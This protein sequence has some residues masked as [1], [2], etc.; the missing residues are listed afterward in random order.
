MYLDRHR[1]ER[2]PIDIPGNVISKVAATNTVPDEV[3]NVF[4]DRPGQEIVPLFSDAC[5]DP[6]LNGL[7][8]V[9]LAWEY[10]GW[11]IPSL[12]VTSNVEPPQPL[13]PDGNEL[14]TPW[15]QSGA[16]AA[17]DGRR[18]KIV[19]Y[20]ELRFKT[21]A[22]AQAL[23]STYA[24]ALSRST[25]RVTEL[26]VAPEL[27][28]RLWDHVTTLRQGDWVRI[29]RTLVT[30]M[31]KVT[32]RIE[33]IQWELTPSKS[34]GQPRWIVTYRLS[35]ISTRLNDVPP[36]VTPPRPPLSPE[37]P[38]LPDLTPELDLAGFGSG[39]LFVTRGIIPN[40]FTLQITDTTRGE[41]RAFIY[42]TDLGVV[43]LPLQDRGTYSGDIITSDFGGIDLPEESFWSVWVRD[44]SNPRRV[45]QSLDQ[46]EIPPRGTLEIVNVQW[47]PRGTSTI[48]YIDDSEAPRRPRI[49]LRADKGGDIEEFRPTIR[50]RIAPT[51]YEVEFRATPLPPNTYELFLQDRSYPERVSNEVVVTKDAPLPRAPKVGYFNPPEWDLDAWQ[52]FPI[53]TAKVA[54]A[55]QYVWYVRSDKDGYANEEL[56]TTDTPTFYLPIPAQS[57][58]QEEINYRVTVATV[59]E[60]GIE[61]P[62]STTATLASG[63]PYARL[64]RKYTATEQNIPITTRSQAIGVYI[65][66]L[67]RPYWGQNQ[68]PDSHDF[69]GV[70][71]TKITA[72][73]IRAVIKNPDEINTRLDYYGDQHRTR[74]DIVTKGTF[75]DNGAGVS[76]GVEGGRRTANTQNPQTPTSVSWNID[77]AVSR[78]VAIKLV[79][80]GWATTGPAKPAAGAGAWI[81]CGEF[82]AE[83]HSYEYLPSRKPR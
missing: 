72:V 13:D 71:I 47:K 81:E 12:V 55:S 65:P 27:D 28:P 19:E 56:H 78:V 51:E 20:S 39:S 11:S 44:A 82:I 64:A 17:A 77:K 69:F 75:V 37:R 14:P 63:Y 32:A 25:I 16:L 73:D 3:R 2:P 36:E 30:D 48:S 23:A 18:H 24:S 76:P 29:E 79:G 68:Y 4:N 8:Y 50:R 80:D 59:S 43:E 45:S 74:L 9:D 70:H 1:F 67:P 52:V 35:A 6:L 83:G 22:E 53:E 54:H 58:N 42:N 10:A 26:V 60:A 40:L 41:H 46:L 49:R 21:T 15:K 31:I 38:P 57:V 33:G 66:K 62:R 7:P 34:G 5:D 61:S